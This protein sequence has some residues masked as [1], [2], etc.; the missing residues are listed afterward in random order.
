MHSQLAL[1][2]LP[3]LNLAPSNL[4][5]PVFDANLLLHHI[6]CVKKEVML[7]QFT[8]ENYI[9]ES[10]KQRLPSKVV[11]FLRLK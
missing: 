6:R 3:P 1:T 4:L 2:E 8:D 11:P 9:P 5:D 7:L 10:A